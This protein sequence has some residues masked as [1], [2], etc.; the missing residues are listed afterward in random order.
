MDTVLQFSVDSV[1]SLI[2]YDKI[3]RVFPSFPEKSWPT[4][5]YQKELAVCGSEVRR[6][7]GDVADHVVRHTLHMPPL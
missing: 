2:E 5:F 6:A 4:P 7:L 3:S 1:N